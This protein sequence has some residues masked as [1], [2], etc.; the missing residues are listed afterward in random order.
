MRSHRVAVGLLLLLVAGALGLGTL[1]EGKNTP[2]DSTTLR[3]SQSTSFVP[4]QNFSVQDIPPHP[5]HFHR[6]EPL[7]PAHAE[8]LAQAR[9]TEAYARHHL[10]ELTARLDLSR[11][12]RDTIFPLL[13]RSSPHYDRSLRLVGS[14]GHPGGALS[15]AEADAQI[16]ELLD[17]YQQVERELSE[18]EKNVWWTDVIDRLEDDLHNSTPT[19]DLP[20][21][22]SETTPPPPNHQGGNLFERLN[23]EGS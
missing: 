11:K 18:A 12:Q 7:P 23:E 20:P 4:H 5:A 17:P 8:D 2:S 21:E 16:H 22:N 6:V 19:G 15:R 13:V 3:L 14:E 10:A 9:Q 1:K